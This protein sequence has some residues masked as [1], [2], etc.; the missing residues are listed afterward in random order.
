MSEKINQ[1]VPL[2]ICVLTV[3]D[4]RSYENDT[5]GDALCESI[6]AEGHTLYK[7]ELVKDDIYQIRAICSAWI[8]DPE[9]QA[10]ITTGGTG[11]AGR[12]STPEAMAPLFDKSIDGFGELFRQLSYEEIGT[13]TIQSRA[14]AGLANNSVIFCLPGSTG[15]CRTGWN[16]IIQPQLSSLTRPCNF[17]GQLTVK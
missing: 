1:F 12:D 2:N 15:A 17:V 16:G 9:A 14:L 13:S 6:K 10:I 3:T 8:A 11:F 7:R 5:S 4:T